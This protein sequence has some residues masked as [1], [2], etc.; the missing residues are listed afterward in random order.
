MS[1]EGPLLE[2]TGLQVAY[3]DRVVLRDLSFVVGRGEVFGLLGPNG[4]GKSTTF[5]VLTGMLAPQ[6][7]SLRFDGRD[8]AP[9]DRNLRTQTGVVFQRPSLDGSLTARENLNLAGALHALPKAEI[10]D[11]TAEM[12][13][14]ADL[15]DR[16]DDAVKT[17]SGGMRRRLELARG[18]MHRPR[19]LLL[20]EP[21]T[22]L[23]EASFQR[24]WRRLEALRAEAGVSMLVSTHRPDE[25][26]RCDRI[27]LVDDGRV[28]ACDTPQNLQQAVR[29]DVVSLEGVQPEEIAAEVQ[30]RFDLEPRI[31]D[32][33]VEFVCERGHELVPR[34]V[35][36][37]PAGRLQAIHLHRPS[38]ADVFLQLT[39]NEL[40]NDLPEP[41]SAKKERRR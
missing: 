33:A 21:T 35:E 25:A 9:G 13:E 14:F 3:G 31:H 39:G 20:D 10:R 22:G 30:S 32:G 26:A 40:L 37:F 38:L 27:A 18:L 2:I 23:D 36:A 4:S 28:V 5:S 1:S 12:L 41:P 17:L 29:G 19:L 11:R 24:T 8:V 7:G 6:A 16:A 15:T 34:L